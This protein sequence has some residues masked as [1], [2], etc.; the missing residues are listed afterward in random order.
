[1]KSRAVSTLSKKRRQRNI[2]FIGKRTSPIFVK[3]VQGYFPN[4]PKNSPQRMPADPLDFMEDDT[5]ELDR[6][7]SP[8]TVIRYQFLGK[9]G[10]S[11][12]MRKEAE[13]LKW[14]AMRGLIYK[15]LNEQKNAEPHIL[16]SCEEADFRHIAVTFISTETLE[17]AHIKC[18]NC[19]DI[20]VEALALGYFPTSSSQYFLSRSTLDLFHKL[21][22]HGCLAQRG[23]C[24]ALQGNW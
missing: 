11:Y 7:P 2:G 10:V 9:F 13:E 18:C 22:Q 3:P 16:C 8:F 17:D 4:H 21:N 5:T 6:P 14:G 12:A 1:M 19:Q 23:F 24:D 20:V 15:Y